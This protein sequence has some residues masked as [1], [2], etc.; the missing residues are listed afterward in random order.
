MRVTAKFR[1][2]E[3]GVT[4]GFVDYFINGSIVINGARLIEGKNGPFI[5]MPTVEVGGEYRDII[6]GISREF[7]D[8]LLNAALAARDSNEKEASIGKGGDGHYEVHIGALD[9]P[10]GATKALASLTVSESIE[11]EKSAFTIHNIRINQGETNMFVGMPS[12]RT[13][14]PQYPY[15]NICAFLGDS[16]QFFDGLIL[17]AAAEKLG[18]NRKAALNDRMMN[19]REK[20]DEKNHV[21]KEQAQEKHME[22]EMAR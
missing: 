5:S 17:G 11:S 9:N 19:A 4:K 3:N 7:S 20:S 12:K 13:N 21:N 14:N 16:K 10:K 2:Y 15:Q 22:A 8:K 1:E 18:L 6:S